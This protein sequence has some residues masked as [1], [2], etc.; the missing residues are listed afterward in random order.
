MNYIG[1]RRDRQRWPGVID[2]K[3][4]AFNR[5]HGCPWA[6]DTYSIYSPFYIM[7]SNDSTYW[8]SASWMSANPWCALDLGAPRHVAKLRLLQSSGS[9]YATQIRIDCMDVWGG[10]WVTVHTS[11]AGLGPGEYLWYPPLLC[12]RYW[13]VT[14]LASSWS[15][16]WV[17]YALELW[18]LAV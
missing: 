2:Q 3:N 18:G 5:V 12:Y 4:Y 8:C 6:I 17:V 15:Y 13:K 7:D 1:A 14:A 11:A 9:E 16:G 10:A